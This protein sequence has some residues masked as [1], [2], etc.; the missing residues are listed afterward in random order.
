MLRGSKIYSSRPKYKHNLNK[1]QM[2]SLYIR[3]I[4]HLLRVATCLAS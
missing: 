2:K 4:V 1:F 3:K